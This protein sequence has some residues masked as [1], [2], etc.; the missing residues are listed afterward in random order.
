[1]AARQ[2]TLRHKITE[3]VLGLFSNPVGTTRLKS[4]SSEPPPLEVPAGYS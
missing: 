3:N 2:L 1:M 4:N